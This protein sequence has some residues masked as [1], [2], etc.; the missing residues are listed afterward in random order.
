MTYPY[1][2]SIDCHCLRCREQTD[3]PAERAVQAEAKEFGDVLRLDSTDTYADL[4]SK[5]L[6]LFGKLPGKVQQQL[7]KLEIGIL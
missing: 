5:T 6:K 7:D 1:P 3:D 4:S 2:S